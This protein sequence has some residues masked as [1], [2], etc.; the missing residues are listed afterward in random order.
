MIQQRFNSKLKVTFWTSI[1]QELVNDILQHERFLDYFNKKAN[2]SEQGLY[3][4]VTIRQVMWA[5]KM[6]PLPKREWETRW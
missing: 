6:K 2:Y 5:L 4:T 3:P 1:D